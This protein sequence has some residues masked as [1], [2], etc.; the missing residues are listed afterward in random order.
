MDLL[1]HF[2]FS[3]SSLQDFVDCRKRFYLRYIQRV[4]W[5]AVQAEPAHEFEEHMHRGQRF[6]HLVQQY[7]TGV[8]VERLDA[9]AQADPDENVLRWWENFVETIPPQL[10]GKRF[11]EIALSA[12]VECHRIVAKYDLIL[13]SESGCVSIFDWKT[14]RHRPRSA[15]LRERL[16]TRVYPFLL[17]QAG[18]AVMP[19]K[20][21]EPEQIE[22]IYWF[23]EPGHEPEH[24]PYDR[25][26]W[27]ADRDYLQGLIREIQTLTHEAYLMCVDEDRCRYC[28]YR[29]LC[30]RGTRAA[31][32]NGDDF[33]LDSDT[34]DDFFTDL[35]Q[36]SE[37]QF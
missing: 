12:P 8:S 30:D 32:L 4:A 10:R 15:T 16:Q 7:L 14:S 24:I 35:E 17:V 9:I 20:H 27:Q 19:G 28:V 21:I 2:E 36:V 3:Q 33:M 22:M 18:A 13:V 5:P 6:H 26:R 34:M 1:D 23:S 31:T 37:I 25:Q 11:V 29:S